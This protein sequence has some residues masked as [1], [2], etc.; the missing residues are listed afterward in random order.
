MFQPNQFFIN[1]LRLKSKIFLINFLLF[2]RS[3]N[4]GCMNKL[5]FYGG[6]WNE[7]KFKI[8]KKLL[9]KLQH[10]TSTIARHTQKDTTHMP[11]KNHQV[12]N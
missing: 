8:H 11:E 7:Q 3:L 5:H 10:K 12:L 1:L 6:F 2:A 9:E 4:D